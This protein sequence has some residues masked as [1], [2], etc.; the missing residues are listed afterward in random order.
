MNLAA[1]ALSFALIHSLWQDAIVGLLLWSALVALRHRSANARYVVCCAALMLMTALPVATTIVLLDQR[2]LS[3]PSSS[4]PVTLTSATG[5]TL[6]IDSVPP[7][8]AARSMDWPAVLTPW[9]LPVWLTGV[10]VCSLRLLMAS[11]HTAAL[12]RRSIPENG[13]LAATVSRLAARIGVN[14]SVSVRVSTV[15]ASPATL[16]FLRPVILLPPA[17]AL[18]ITP[19]QLEALLAHE[20]AHVRRHDYLVNVLQMFAET[21]FFYHPVVWWTSR[22]I[23][24]ER[25]LCC[26]DIAVRACGDAVSYA[27]ALTVVARLL[28]TR[29][30]MAVGAAG[31]PLLVRVQ[32]L[33]GVASTSRQV[34]PLWIAAAALV[35]IVALMFVGPYA[36]SRTPDAPA[37]GTVERETI[38]RGRVVDAGTGSP[39]AG[40][41]VRA[42][43][44]TGVE[45][46]TRCP[47]GDCEGIVNGPSG[48]I[49]IYR[50]TTDA[51][52]R[53]DFRDMKPGDYL[54]AAVA[55]G[56]VQRHYGETSADTPEMPVHVA[57]GERAPSIDVRLERAGSVS[58]HILSDGGEGLPGVEVELLRRTYLP[59]GSQQVPIAFAQTEERGEFRFGDVTPGEYYVRAYAARA[60][61]PTRKEGVSLSYAATYFPETVDVAFAQ[62]LLLTSGQELAG[63]DFALMTAKMSVVSGRLVDPNGASLLTA[64]VHLIPFPMGVDEVRRASAATD[65]RFRFDNVAASKYML[66][67]SDT[68][69]GRSWNTVVH[70]VIVPGDVT[71]L[72]LVAGP[73]VWLEGRVVREDGRP[74]PFDPS[75]LRIVT[76]QRTSSAGLHSAGSTKIESNGN[77]LMRSGAGPMYLRI[78]GLPPRWFVK[79]AQLDGLEVADGSFDLTPGRGRRLDITLTDRVSRL[80]GTVTDRSARPVT[81]ALVV[82][83]PDDRAR[84]MRP[85]NLAPGGSSCRSIFTTF[86]RQ[87]G[88][89]AIDALPMSKYRVVAVTFLPR[90]AWTDPDVL[91]RLWP[92]ASPLSLDAIGESALNLR[93]VEPPA[94]L[95][96]SAH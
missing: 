11:L 16:G 35:M 49:P 31:G 3:P 94:D 37:P 40:A 34:S 90:N 88:R 20:L 56:Y 51:D 52:G 32:R 9:L 59:G 84:W 17:T 79:S 10:A 69:D 22:R 87:Q 57:A 8:G 47:I 28:V 39:V 68:L 55:P 76:E 21:L 23:R 93:V 65:G 70:D 12:K 33:L 73:S 29:P 2:E 19:Q 80:S 45:N 25:E 13:P 50:A 91:E 43:Y 5:D 42:Q 18:H 81:N 64:M 96:Q 7:A 62:P 60:I 48:P 36:Q 44:I 85:C 30:G 72:L 6:R 89:Y 58:G 66:T 78:D 92:S 82:V 74:L 1:D 75:E 95:L 14:R 4:A 53:F 61:E 15:M 54:V 27:Q 24:I 63:V 86:S 77:F 46:P 38:L 41:S 71:D 26:D 83:F 67:V